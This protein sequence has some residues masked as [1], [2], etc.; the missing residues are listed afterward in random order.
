MIDRANVFELFS[1]QENHDTSR[2][3]IISGCFVSGELFSFFS[4]LPAHLPV[5]VA[6]STNRSVAVEP[7]T[8][9]A[10]VG[11]ALVVAAAVVVVK[12]GAAAV[13]VVAVV[14][15]VVVAV[16]TVLLEGLLVANSWSDLLSSPRICVRE[17]GE[18][19]RGR[20][21]KRERERRGI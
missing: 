19:E 15:V 14:V 2:V 12:V 6:V 20:N 18:G 5:A 7:S 1:K 13:V 9:L 16:V 11:F 8:T 10:A 17:R 21:S 4:F 3:L